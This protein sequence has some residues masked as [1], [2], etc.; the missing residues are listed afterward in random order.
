[1]VN[2]HYLKHNVQVH[3]FYYLHCVKKILRSLTF[4][5]FEIN[6]H[7]PLVLAKRPSKKQAQN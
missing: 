2:M 4:L 7:Q 1:M 5:I 6:V 3:S